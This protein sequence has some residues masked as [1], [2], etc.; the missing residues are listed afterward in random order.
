VQRRPS[1]KCTRDRT[2]AIA[3]LDGASPKWMG[4]FTSFGT[5]IAVNIMSGVVAS[6]FVFFA[7]LITSGSLLGFFAVMLSLTV[8]TTAVSYF[9]IFPALV[10][11]RKL[12]P[13]AR[14]PYR[15][16]G[17]MAGAWTATI[18]TEVSHGQ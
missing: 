1:A 7:F 2:Q 8:S 17:G 13:E 9:F 11:L 12:Y 18:I 14:R 10:R 5:L 15:V 3:S 4:R 16:P 6:I